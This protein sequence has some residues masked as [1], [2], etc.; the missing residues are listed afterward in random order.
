MYMYIYT[1]TEG[2]TRRAHNTLRPSIRPLYTFFYQIGLAKEREKKT[3]L[4]CYGFLFF[5]GFVKMSVLSFSWMACFCH[6]AY[7]HMYLLPPHSPTPFEIDGVQEYTH[8][9]HIY[10][11]HLIPYFY[12]TSD[13]SGGT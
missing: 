2:C 3:P 1:Q 6:Q 11:A 12:F 8:I 10:W 13:R 7:I 4:I 9:I 5:V